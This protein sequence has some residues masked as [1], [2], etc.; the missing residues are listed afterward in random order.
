MQARSTANDSN[1]KNSTVLEYVHMQ[2]IKT[3]SVFNLES[4]YYYFVKDVRFDIDDS[5]LE[6]V[7]PF[8]HYALVSGST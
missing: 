7:W 2:M 4:H 3:K 6:K 5:T 8:C 1:D